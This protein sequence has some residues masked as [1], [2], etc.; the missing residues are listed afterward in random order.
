MGA[1]AGQVPLHM[2]RAV[3]PRL[4]YPH[5]SAC[6]C[7]WVLRVGSPPSMLPATYQYS[8]PCPVLL[9]AEGLG[10][11]PD[12]PSTAGGWQWGRPHTP[13]ADELLLA[14]L[15]EGQELGMW[16]CLFPRDTRAAS[17]ADP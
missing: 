5:S 2:L 16:Q 3:H 9:L 10:D 12:V 4:L 6:F 14:V 11:K 13:T 15:P 17:D 7:F 1:Q 8:L